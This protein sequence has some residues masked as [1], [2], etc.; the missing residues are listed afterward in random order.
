MFEKV[1]EMDGQFLLWIQE[2]I[3]TD[4][5]TPIVKG[6]T[7]SANGGA[8]LI[9]AALI[10]MIIPKTRKLGFLCAAALVFNTL[11]CNVILKNII[12][13]VRPYEVID[14]LKLMVGKQNDWSF[15]SGHASGGFCMST[16]IF[17]EAPRKIGIPVLIFALLIS[18]SRLYVGVHYPSDVICGIILG[19]LTGFFTCTVYHRAIAKNKMRLHRD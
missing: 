15:P 1:I 11:I 3:R 10:L 19:T 13:R 2:N 16:V 4:A 14:D 8:I 18:L 12:A 7:Y 5:L 6:I 17:R 9:A